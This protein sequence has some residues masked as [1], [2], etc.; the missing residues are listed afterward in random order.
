VSAGFRPTYLRPE[1]TWRLGAVVALAM[2]EAAESL[3]GLARGS[4]RLKWPND[5]VIEMSDGV[6]KLGGV[7]GESEGLGTVDVRAIVGIGVN[8]DWTTHAVP[9]DLAPTMTSLGAASGKTVDVA[10]LG[11]AFLDCLAHL[12]VRLRDGEFPAAAWTARQVTTGR[13]VVLEMPGGVRREAR[14]EGVDTGSGALL[15]GPST[16]DASPLSVHAADVVHVR[17]AGPGA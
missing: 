1:T 14:A 13:T 17:L 2:A 5:L 4:V 8:V 15:I 6:R 9:D 3:A 11:D 10:R 7:L 12:A 16:I